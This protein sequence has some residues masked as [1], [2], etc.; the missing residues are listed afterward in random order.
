MGGPENE[1]RRSSPSTSSAALPEVGSLLSMQGTTGGILGHKNVGLDLPHA[2]PSSILG[3]AVLLSRKVGD[4]GEMARS[5]TDRGDAGSNGE[6]SLKYVVTVR[7]GC[8]GER[9]ELCGD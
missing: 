6:A 9:K 8:G 2:S 4:V 5:K 3:V 1:F 7:F